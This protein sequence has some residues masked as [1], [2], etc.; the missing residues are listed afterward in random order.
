M[1]KAI[2]FIIPVC[3]ALLIGCSGVKNIAGPATEDKGS[4]ELEMVLHEPGVLAKSAVVTLTKLY[5]TLSANKEAEIK[6]T[7]TISG[8][9]DITMNRT[10]NDLASYKNWTI[11]AYSEDQSATTI[12]S[13]NANFYILPDE[14]VSAQLQLNPL[15]SIL[16]ARFTEIP[17]LVNKI[18]LKVGNNVLDQKDIT[19]NQSPALTETLTFDYLK[20]DKRHNVELIG[21]GEL[22]G[23]Q[24]C[25]YSGKIAL[26]P[27]AGVDNSYEVTLSW[28]G[29]KKPPKGRAKIMVEISAAGVDNITGNFENH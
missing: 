6:D 15:Y 19:P 5:I 26:R 7:V 28:V 8:T 9:G 11:T 12:H 3:F 16:I 22:W 20:V 17:A 29:P 10:D 27:A 25:L 14:T 2:S 21:Y 23:K 4:L 1:E 13:G 18:E 24:E